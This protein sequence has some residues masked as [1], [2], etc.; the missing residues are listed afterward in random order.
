MAWLYKQ[1]ES[2]NWWIGQRINGRQVRKSTG[3]SDETEAKRL[4]EEIKSMESASR[5]G[6]LTEAFYRELTGQQL[7]AVTLK[8]AISRWHDANKSS[9]AKSTASRYEDVTEQFSDYM[10]ATDSRP[11]LRDVTAADITGYLNYSGQTVAPGSLVVARKILS[12]FWNWC[13]KQ[14]PRL[15]TENPVKA[16]KLPRARKHQTIRRRPFATDELKDVFTKAKTPFWKYMVTGG[17]YTGLRMGDLVCLSRDEVDLSRNLLRLEANKTFGRSKAIEVPIAS[18]F[19]A[20][21]AP[22]MKQSKGGQYLWPERAAKYLERGPA[23]FSNEFYD[24]VLVPAG[25]AEKRT[26]KKSKDGNGRNGKR[27]ISELTFH[28]FRHT[29]VS[30]LKTSGVSQSV[31]KA[32]AG[33]ASDRISDLYTTVSLEHMQAAIKQLPEV[34]S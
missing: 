24:E 5:A 26:H 6:K 28:C 4:L 16:T 29:F 2:E 7:A 3:T 11:L 32:L 17:L 8:A 23:S 1:P 27:R 14:T 30:L 9:T 20:I 21:L 22:L 19:R 12:A 13:M 31:A 34:S 25:L 10:R 18:P 33:H 15:A